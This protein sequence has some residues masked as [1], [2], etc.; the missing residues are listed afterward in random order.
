MTEIFPQPEKTKKPAT[1]RNDFSLQK[2]SGESIA[3]N[4]DIAMGYERL[5]R[6]NNERETYP[7]SLPINLVTELRRRRQDC[8]DL[9]FYRTHSSMPAHLPTSHIAFHGRTGSRESGS[10]L[11]TYP[12]RTTVYK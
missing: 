6:G 7:V 11:G 4:E 9:L 8:N 3:E 10:L 1:F 2:R 12:Y 5:G